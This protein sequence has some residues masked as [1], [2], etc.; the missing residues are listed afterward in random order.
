MIIKYFSFLT[1]KGQ[2]EPRGD[3]NSVSAT[4]SVRQC[5]W[6]PNATSDPT[7]PL[8]HFCW[9]L[10]RTVSPAACTWRRHPLNCRW[11]I[12]LLDSLLQGWFGWAGADHQRVRVNAM[13]RDDVSASLLARRFQ[14]GFGCVISRRPGK[15]RRFQSKGYLT[16]LWNH[17]LELEGNRKNLL[18]FTSEE[19]EA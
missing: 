19:T 14:A 9:R 2:M 16:C 12:L 17:S 11:N 15:S 18:N 3:V 1:W 10:T 4:L 7:L 6:C 8:Y 5:D 13:D